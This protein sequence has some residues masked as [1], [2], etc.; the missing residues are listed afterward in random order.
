MFEKKEFK[1]KG[2]G[3]KLITADLTFKPTEEE[4]PICIFLHGFKGFKDWGS[5]PLAA[6][7]FAIKELPFFKINFSHNGTSPAHP[8]EFVDLDAFGKN[9]LSMELD[10]TGL[11]LDFIEK[12]REKLGFNWNGD[13]YLIGHS[14]GGGIALLK[15][16]QDD[17]IQKVVTW[18]AVADFSRY[19]QLA[20]PIEWQEKGFITVPN[21][22]TGQEMPVGFELYQDYFKNEDQLNIDR[23][24]EK[25]TQPLMVIHG[26]EDETVPE[27]HAMFIYEN[28]PHAILITLEGVD[29]SFGLSHPL[30]ERKI[31]ANFARVL[32]ETIEFLTM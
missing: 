26:E 29:H 27:S 8:T 6:E 23:N 16:C 28:V 2:S 1:F 31:N 9:T 12:N 13:F 10:E 3:K 14:R 7:V 17:R 32:E 18:A 25:L 21:S 30:T 4:R 20:D 15:A 24:L 5:W 19:I 11:A 22:R